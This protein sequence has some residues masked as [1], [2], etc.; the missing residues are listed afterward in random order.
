MQC[1]DCHEWGLTQ[2]G[3]N[4]LCEGYGIKA[5]AGT[6]PAIWIVLMEENAV[7]HEKWPSLL[8][9]HATS[10]S[11]IAV[12]NMSAACKITAVLRI[13]E[14]EGYVFLS[15][16]EGQDLCYMACL[17]LPSGLSE[18]GTAKWDRLSPC[19]LLWVNILL[20]CIWLILQTRMC[21]SC[22]N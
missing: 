22:M 18:R 20:K 1:C 15:S 17:S 19:I 9:S 14:V 8:W 2:R 21:F 11:S 13:A 10:Y 12:I 7:L 5:P 6:F 3:L 4:P 16:L